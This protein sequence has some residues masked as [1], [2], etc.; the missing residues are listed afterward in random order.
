MMKVQG[1]F[2]GFMTDTINI[3]VLGQCYLDNIDKYDYIG[4]FDN[5][6]TVLPKIS[7]QFSSIAKSIEQ[8]KSFKIDDLNKFNDLIFNDKCNHYKIDLIKNKNPNH[9][10]PYLKN[11]EYNQNIK[12]SSLYFYQGYFFSYKLTERLFNYVTNYFVNSKFNDTQLKININHDEKF[13]ITEYPINRCSLTIANREEYNYL[14][15]LIQIVNSLIKPYLDKNREIINKFVDRYER[16]FVILKN[17]DTLGKT[18]HNTKSTFEFSLHEPMLYLKNV[19]DIYTKIENENGYLHHFRKSLS[20]NGI[21][22]DVYD[23]YLDLNFFNCYFVPI[24]ESFKN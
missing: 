18:I 10:Y 15:N 16:F 22:F 19:P 20:Q 6:E 23:I 14:M 3:L 1:D 12:E 4:V 11:V 8:F 2:N 5:D 17:R 7:D 24:I 21:D 9:I 13:V